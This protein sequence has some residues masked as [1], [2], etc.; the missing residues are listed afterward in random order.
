MVD[1]SQPSPDTAYSMEAAEPPT[2]FGMKLR[3][4]IREKFGLL[5]FVLVLAV[6]FALPTLLFERTRKVV[7]D[8]ELMDLQDEAELRCWEIIDWV[9]QARL[10]VEHCAKDPR[11]LATMKTCLAEFS[12]R[13]ASAERGEQEWWRYVLA[14]EVRPAEGAMQT[15][16]RTPGLPAVEPPAA[17]LASA[18]FTSGAHI[19]PIISLLT[20]AGF[21]PVSGGAASSG[22]SPDR[23]QR[24][25]AV[26]VACSMPS[27]PETVI[28]MLVTL[29]RGRS[30]R[31]LTFVMG[32]DGSFL[33]HPFVKPD[34]KEEQI[35]AGFDLYAESEALTKGE[36]WGRGPTEAQAQVQR[37]DR[38]RFQVLQSPLY[39]L[40]G[41]LKP[42]M[43]EKL[44]AAHD[45][46]RVEL[47]DWTEHVRSGMESRGVP[48]GGASRS[49]AGIRLLSRSK[50]VLE[51]ARRDTE[52]EY[53][54]RFGGAADGKP[55]DWEAVV[56]L[57]HG[58]VQLTRFHLR[59]PQHDGTVAGG[60][61]IPYY[62]A[63]SAFREELASSIA[64]ELQ[65]LR[66]AGLW[67]AVGAGVAAFLI[68]LYFIGPLTRITRTAQT[69]THSGSE[70]LQLQNQIEAVR[71]SL[72]VRKHDEV[73]DIARSLEAL[74]RQ[75]LNGHE[76]LRQLN[77]DLDFR[78]QEQTAE[79]RAANEQLRGLASAKDAFLASVSHELRQP[80]NSIF[81]FLQFLELSDP[82]EEQ[83]HDLSKLRSAATYLRRLI[84]DIL[85]YQ[86]IIMGGVEL[87]PEE[88]D[89]AAFLT[90]L[91]DS[92]VPQ[93]A[94][95]KNKLELGGA[96]SL[97]IIFND[98]ARLQQVLTNLVSNACKFTQNGTVTLNASR[99]T[100]AT[101]KDWISIDVSDTG[102]GMKPEEMQGL[103]VRF[104]KLS[105]REGNKT[106]TGLGLVISKGL[107]ELM[108]G[109]ITCRS[110]FGQGSTFTVRVPAAVPERSGAPR[111]PLEQRPA[112]PVTTASLAAAAT[113]APTIPQQT[114]LVI[115][116]DAS[117]REL[118]T[119]YLGGKGYRV[120][121][122]EDGE[123]GMALAREQHPS[124]ITLDVVLPGAQS[125]WDILSQLK[126][127]PLTASIPVIIVT[128]LEETRHGFALGAADYV[129]KPIAWEDL[130][131]S[132]QKVIRGS[133]PSLP[134][135]VVDD[136]PDVRELFRRT[137]AM[138]G[139]SIIEAANGAEALTQLRKQKPSLILLDLMMPVMDGFEFIAEFNLHAQWRDIPVI[140]I[141]AK[142]VT[143]E[144]RERLATS[145][146]TVLEKS[147]FTQEDLLNKVLHLVHQAASGEGKRG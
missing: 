20:P 50:E 106:G 87:D 6:A 89:A 23:W 62:F 10:Q 137:L 94:E 107:C 18:R 82:T 140:V 66:R 54:Y 115:D 133:A 16:H 117:V 135:L 8:H 49:S 73:G 98:R 75:V 104:K 118:M 25:P 147:G 88:L 123:K 41:R 5:A 136:D 110:E 92:M 90:S 85:D 139:I 91:R 143:R 69:V 46:N 37:S 112:A 97:G 77:A 36:K 122:A 1:K 22:A 70:A 131:G 17:L 71:Q 93:A 28:T 7:E 102:R 68:V 53:F 132:L 14:L 21:N 99:D 19:G 52:Q 35:Y 61:D 34:G 126:D 79:V 109:T 60:R 59:H 13:G 108:G 124:V 84:D 130:L 134:V 95:K 40:E 56:R 113:P 121:T 43:H 105:A 63:Y 45:A 83:K 42:A 116:D 51:Q 67:L 12:S 78:V 114:V 100:D 111:R 38:P 144:D 72:P 15:F 141:T 120:I 33:Q 142:H 80:L 32:P 96:E 57:D 146:R 145:V 27:V 24:I 3:F 129:V 138:D 26:W 65:T 81:G 86:K 103:F 4:G 119:R 48:F 44:V 39:F 31:H 58:D 64:H 29:D 9:N 101:G 127:E 55:I 125:G 30:A 2:W 74:L 11:E 76:Q 128:F 47:L